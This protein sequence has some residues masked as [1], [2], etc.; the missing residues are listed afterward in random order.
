MDRPVDA[1]YRRKRIFKRALSAAAVLVPLL[2]LFGLAPRWIRPA[3]SRSDVR[4]ATVDAGPIEATISASGTVVPE[5]EQV[6]SSPIDARVVKILKRPGAVLKKGE[7]IIDLDV[8]ESLLGLEKLN[9]QMAL[10]QNQQSRKKLDLESTL[11][12]KKSQLR[13]RE[14][15]VESL[16]I[17]VAKQKKLR[18]GG[19]NSEEQ[20]RQA[21]VDAEKAKVEVQ[22]LRESIANAER[23]TAAEL[24]GVTLEIATLKKEREQSLRLLER[25]TTK[26]DRDGVLT[27]V[28]SEEGALVRKGDVVARIADLSTFRVDATISDIHASHLRTGMPARIKI[29]DTDWLEGT[30][31]TVL[32]TIKDGIMTAQ[33]TLADKSN[34]LLRSNLRVDAF[35][36]TDRRQKALR[37]KRGAYANT[38]GVHDLFVVRGGKAVK[39][40]VRIGL[41]SFDFCE[42]VDGLLAGDEVIISDMKDYSH[43]REVAFQ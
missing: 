40:P 38:E 2:A 26:A 7:P 31:A 6:L 16:D 14:I 12:A 39:M 24:E 8:S 27:W 25:A 21:E 15:D 5:F 23:A 41:S 10:K 4:L 11:I 43:L 42:I 18:A 19:L 9:E 30:I 32:P 33:I 37:L 13:L 17:Q 35:V 22:Q 29:T 36:V 1:Q 28:V 3:V 34:K 20:L